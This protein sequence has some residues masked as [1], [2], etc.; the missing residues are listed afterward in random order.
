MNLD[1]G[2]VV[3]I[4]FATFLEVWNYLQ[5]KPKN[6]PNHYVQNLK[7]LFFFLNS[8]PFFVISTQLNRS[9]ANQSSTQKFD[10]ESGLYHGFSSFLSFP[11]TP[12]THREHIISE[13]I[14]YLFFFIQLYQI[15]WRSSHLASL[16]W[17][18]ATIYKWSP[19]H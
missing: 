9:S 13:Y 1:K 15:N 19:F 7:T 2:H 3:I 5:R 4:I 6:K 8:V 16:V 17:F 12:H 10:N 11:S 18:T 14:L